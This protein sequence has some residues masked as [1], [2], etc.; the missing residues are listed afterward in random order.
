M[1]PINKDHF[2][3]F[4]DSISLTCRKFAIMANVDLASGFSLSSD[5]ADQYLRL[6]ASHQHLFLK[7]FRQIFNYLL[8]ATR[9]T[10]HGG[11]LFTYFL[12]N[13]KRREHDLK[14]SELD[15]LTLLYYHSSGGKETIRSDRVKE[16]FPGVSNRTF[17][18]L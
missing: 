14:V 6:S 2:V 1:F 18:S 11:V 9:I 3:L 4:I 7:L 12:V 5:L 13:Q 10:S 8:P 17:A 16:Q 15:L